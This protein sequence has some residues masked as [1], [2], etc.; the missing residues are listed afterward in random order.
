MQTLF[1]GYRW[2]IVDSLLSFLW[3]RKVE[4]ILLVI[5]MFS[6]S[7]ILLWLITPGRGSLSNGIQSYQA[8]SWSNIW[9]FSPHWVLPFLFASRPHRF[10]L[11]WRGKIIVAPECLEGFNSI[12]M[13]AAVIPLSI[14]AIYYTRMLLSSYSKAWITFIWSLNAI[15][16]KLRLFIFWEITLISYIRMSWES[17]SVWRLSIFYSP[18]PPETPLLNNH[19]PTTRPCRLLVRYLHPLCLDLSYYKLHTTN[20]Q[21]NKS[22]IFQQ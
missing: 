16:R 3:G 6:S 18:D 15:S 7:C 4:S 14:Q 10:L 1:L 2:W 11:I 13:K 22:T 17:T 5:F 20:K 8:R 19:N 9:S 21:F 12:V